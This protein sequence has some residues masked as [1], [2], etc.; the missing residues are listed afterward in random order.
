MAGDEDIKNIEIVTD[1]KSIK[2]GIEETRRKI[3]AFL[4]LKPMTVSELAQAIGKDQ[5][6]IYR[7]IEKLADFH[8]IKVSGERKTHHIPEK[9]YARTANTFLLS[10]D[11]NVLSQEVPLLKKFRE[12]KAENLAKALKEMEPASDAN[13]AE[14]VEII[15][16]IY[17]KTA[18]WVQELKQKG[19]DLPMRDLSLFQTLVVIK[20]Y[21][22]DAEFRDTLEALLKQ[23]GI[24]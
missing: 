15:S 19:I 22:T 2:V 17:D 21:R 20:K 11:K 14:I 16:F 10:P 12:E 13:V 6:T 8:Y 1:P 18:E 4:R 3:L 9:V 5:S 24:E 7:H 23:A